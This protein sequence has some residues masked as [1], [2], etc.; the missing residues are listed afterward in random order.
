MPFHLTS[1]AVKFQGGFAAKRLA[2]ESRRDDGTFTTIA[3]FFPDDHGKLQI[4]FFFICSKER[5]KKI[6]SFCFP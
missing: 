5:E 2:F 4:S 1:F 3:E 6:T